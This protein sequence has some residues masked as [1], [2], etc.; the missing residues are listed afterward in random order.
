MAFIGEHDVF[1]RDAIGFHGLHDLGLEEALG[2]IDLTIRPGQCFGLLGP[3]GAGKSTTIHILTGLVTFRRGDVQVVGRDVA[4]DY[5]STR[6][7]IGLSPQ[8]FRFDRF[9]PIREILIQKAQDFHALE[10]EGTTY[11]CGDKIGLLRANVA[12]AL[13]R[14]ELKDAARRAIQELL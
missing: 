5:R 4:R 11:D 8:E 12:F 9:F 6:R 7:A 14:P 2:G 10:Y 1:H 13:M 3:N